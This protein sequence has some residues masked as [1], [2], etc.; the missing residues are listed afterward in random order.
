MQYKRSSFVCTL[1][2]DLFLV[3]LTSW[4][5][6]LTVFKCSVILFLIIIIEEL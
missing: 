4:Y 5:T 2:S 6:H 1:H 3:G